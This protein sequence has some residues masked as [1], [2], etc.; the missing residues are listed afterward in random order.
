MQAPCRSSLQPSTQLCSVEHYVSKQVFRGTGGDG[1]KYPPFLRTSKVKYGNEL[2]L[3]CETEARQIRK[4]A[5]CS[6]FLPCF[7][8]PIALFFFSL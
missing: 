2:V 7:A 6:L 4:A 3:C 1:L 5:A 8:N